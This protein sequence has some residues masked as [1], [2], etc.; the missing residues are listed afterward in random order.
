[1]SDANL[2]EDIEEPSDEVKHLLARIRSLPDGPER[3]RLREQRWAIFMDEAGGT[4]EATPPTP[5]P[6]NDV[7]A[8][9]KLTAKEKIEKAKE[10]RIAA[11][12]NNLDTDAIDIDEISRD[13]PPPIYRIEGLLPEDSLSLVSAY[14]DGFKSWLLYSMAI[15]VSTG[16]PWLGRFKTVRANALII[17][18]EQGKRECK[19]R[20]RGLLNGLGLTPPK[21]SIRLMTM[22]ELW[23]F[24][25]DLEHILV[26]LIKKHDYRLVVTDSLANGSEGSGV[27]ENDSR[28]AGP[29]RVLKRVA[30][31]TGCTFV[32]I[33][34]DRKTKVDKEGETITETDKRQTPRGT[35]AIFNALDQSFSISTVSED[36]F[37]VEHVKPRFGIKHE[38]F[39]VTISGQAPGAVTM[40]A[41][42][43]SESKSAADASRLKRCAEKF[44]T[45]LRRHPDGLSA[46]KLHEAVGGTKATNLETIKTVAKA[47][48][49]VARDGR[50]F[51]PGGSENGSAKGPVEPVAEPVA[52]EVK[53]RA[54]RKSSNRS[55]SGKTVKS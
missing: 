46:N 55:R 26:A 37:H 40:T 13:D 21:G 27:S 47:G 43:R 28:F 1:M 14:G 10:E 3:Q 53:V 11:R 17:D 44:V 30:S 54:V 8:P 2:I 41:T 31:R 7:A 19:R 12:V 39:T 42:T 49:I 52:S 24:E 32:V 20:L 51:A 25:P 5:T 48:F 35:G 4:R 6:A 36:V 22:P 33:H 50:Y 18:Y 16:T 45:A 9:K 15:A 23:L 38:P 34:H 29:L